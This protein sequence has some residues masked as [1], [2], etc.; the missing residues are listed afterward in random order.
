MRRKVA[1]QRLRVVLLSG[2]SGV[3]ERVILSKSGDETQIFGLLHRLHTT[4]HAQ[5][6]E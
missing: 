6:L 4:V 5:L 1:S 2:D 3:N